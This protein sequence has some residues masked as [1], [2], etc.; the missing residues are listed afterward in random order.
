MKPYPNRL[1][2][3]SRI[4][5]TTI[6]GRSIVDQIEAVILSNPECSRA[7]SMRVDRLLFCAEAFGGQG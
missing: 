3:G 2:S 7:A 4:T 1:A 6:L 5:A